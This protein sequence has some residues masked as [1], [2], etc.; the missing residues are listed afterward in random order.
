MGI[1]RAVEAFYFSGEC[2]VPDELSFPAGIVDM[3]LSSLSSSA[4]FK[5]LALS[6]STFASAV[7]PIERYSR[8]SL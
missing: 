8:A 4:L 1:V 3:I 2:F 5:L 7:I 6:N